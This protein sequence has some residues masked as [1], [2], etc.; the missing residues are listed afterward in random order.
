MCVS[1]V[2]RIKD[3]FD[4]PGDIMTGMSIGAW[5]GE[6][7]SYL[8][9]SHEDDSSSEGNLTAVLEKID[10]D[11]KSSVQDIASYQVTNVGNLYLLY[12][13]MFISV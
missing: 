6:I 1:I 5:I 10:A 2:K 7:P 8:K 3:T 12:F 13:S 9:L 11:I 4:W